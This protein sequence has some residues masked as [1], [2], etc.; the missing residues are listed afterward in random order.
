[1]PNALWYTSK[2]LLY[3]YSTYRQN[4]SLSLIRCSD[5]Y[6]FTVF[7]RAN[8]PHDSELVLLV[9]RLIAQQ[10]HW[11]GLRR[12]YLPSCA[13]TP[14]LS[15]PALFGWGNKICLL[16][17]PV[18]RSQKWVS[19]QGKTSPSIWFSYRRRARASVLGARDVQKGLKRRYIDY[20][21][22]LWILLPSGKKNRNIKARVWCQM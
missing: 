7:L 11:N 5:T 22:Q 15:L 18:V 20:E 19:Q 4:S 10:S 9:S 13:L 8:L 14:T 3:G 12:V 1:M 16:S 21:I 6:K 17:H 2:W